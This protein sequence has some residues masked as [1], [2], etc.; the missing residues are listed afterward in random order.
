[1]SLGFLRYLYCEAML[2]EKKR[3]ATR[4]HPVSMFYLL[5]GYSDFFA[6]EFLDIQDGNR[7]I[8]IV[9]VIFD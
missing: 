3:D 6:L 5:N 1:M 2:A 7:H 4:A 8:L 9:F